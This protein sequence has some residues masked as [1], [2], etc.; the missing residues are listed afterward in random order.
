MVAV[1]QLQQ[2]CQVFAF[3]ALLLRGLPS[4]GLPDIFHPVLHTSHIQLKHA[5]LTFLQHYQYIQCFILD[6]A[7]IVSPPLPVG[8]EFIAVPVQS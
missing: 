7:G 4:D 3:P 1:G 8:D 6:D 5:E 2:W